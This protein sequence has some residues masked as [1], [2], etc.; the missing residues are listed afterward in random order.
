MVPVLGLIVVTVG[1][2]VATYLIPDEKTNVSYPLSSVAS[3]VKSVISGT[4]RSLRT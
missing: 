1:V 4:V 2:E 3:T